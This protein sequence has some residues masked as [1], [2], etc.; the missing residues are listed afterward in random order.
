MQRMVMLG[1]RIAGLLAFCILSS[2]SR[3]RPCRD[4]VI[5]GALVRERL[6]GRGNRRGWLRG[7]HL[8]ESLRMR[9]E[10]GQPDKEEDGSRVLKSSIIDYENPIIVID[11]DYEGL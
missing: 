6:P 4:E 10:H 7:D 9:S 3:G 2:S 8:T 1:R 5:N 11:Y